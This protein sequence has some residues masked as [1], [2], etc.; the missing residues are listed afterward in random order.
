MHIIDI[1]TSCNDCSLKE[2]LL[3]VK[4]ILG[5]IQLLGPL[6]AIVS[7]VY[8]FIMLVNKPDDKKLPKRITNSL[9]ALII[10]FFIP[11]IVNTVFYILDDSFIVS[12]C[13]NNIDTSSNN[14]AQYIEI[15]VNRERAKIV[16]DPSYFQRGTAKATT[17]TNRDSSSRTTQKA[18]KII[19]IGDS[20]T[21]QMYAT[22][23]G[24]WTSSNYSDGGVHM[25]GNDIY[26]AQVAKGLNWMKSTGM[27]AAKQYFGSG[28]AIVILMGV[29]DVCM[30]G[31]NN[32]GTSSIVSDYVNY[33]NS[34]VNSWKS[35]GSSVYFV[36]VN[37]CS[38]SYSHMNSSI[39][40]FNSSIKS[41]LSNQVN[42]L[43]TYTILEQ[44]GFSSG[45]GLH[46][47]GATYKLIHDYIKSKV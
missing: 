2:I 34:N 38:G 29:N 19:F 27:P 1:I 17:E 32:S 41:K 35:S 25:V 42:W 8:T 10:M 30:Y 23:S 7:L 21:T 6:L 20:R 36:S 44:N 3:I 18:N 22:Y 28:T 15:D 4:K 40:Y 46:Y 31:C 11:V 16:S 39:Q 37:P 14:K 33:I 24:N 13:W 26:V 47:G 12:S 45:D 5:L 43:D 9:L